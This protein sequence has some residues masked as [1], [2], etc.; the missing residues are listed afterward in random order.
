MAFNGG[1][2]P[3]P[4]DRRKCILGYVVA[5]SN[6]GGGYLVLRLEDAYPHNVVGTKQNLNSL[7][8]LESKIYNEEREIV[9]ERAKMFLKIHQEVLDDTYEKEYY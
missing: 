4:A 9:E 1:S 5:L 7:G 8:E 6:E 2:K 3:K